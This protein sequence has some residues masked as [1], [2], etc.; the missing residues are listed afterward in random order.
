MDDVSQA[1]EVQFDH[2]SADTPEHHL[3]HSQ[4]VQ[5]LRQALDTLPDDTRDVVV[6]YYR[7]QQSSQH[8]AELLGLTNATVRQRLARARAKLADNLMK[9][10]GKAAL[11][12]APSLSISVILGGTLTFAAPPAAAAGLGAVAHA[13]SFKWLAIFG[14][15]V[16]AIFGALAGVLIGAHQAEKWAKSETDKACL[17]KI[18]NQS[19]GFVIIAGTLFI[20]SYQID[21]GWMLPLITYAVFV[22][23]IEVFQRKMRRH[24]KWPTNKLWQCYLG[25]V[26]GYGC[27]TLG[28]VMGLVASGR[29]AV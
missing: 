2:D 27:G 17:R 11:F 22:A 23:G 3:S 18:R 7:E 29:F 13:S 26:L 4:Q 8:V 16:L 1:L 9:K 12:T 20:S 19:A 25:Q 5:V 6:L 14:I 28:L 15:Y 21:D 10:V 24:I